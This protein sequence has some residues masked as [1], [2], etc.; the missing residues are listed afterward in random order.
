MAWHQTS[1]RWSVLV[2]GKDKFSPKRWKLLL[3]PSLFDVTPL[4]DVKPVVESMLKVEGFEEIGTFSFSKLRSTS[5]EDDAGTHPDEAGEL[6]EPVSSKYNIQNSKY[7]TARRV[8]DET[9]KRASKID[10]R[11][12][13]M[14]PSDR[15]SAGYAWRQSHPG[16]TAM[17]N[18]RHLHHTGIV[19]TRQAALDYIE[20][21]RKAD[22]FLPKME[23]TPVL[24]QG[25]GT[26]QTP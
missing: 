11:N 3:H 14:T 23:V 4:Q 2:Q 13:P 1:S 22:T 19:M 12:F 25:W 26:G 20:Y 24:N 17:A 10:P 15:Q 21:L 5:R 9:A 8:Y 16:E 18:I 7:A 6:D